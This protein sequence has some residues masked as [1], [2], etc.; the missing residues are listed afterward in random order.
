M[1][2]Y[3]LQHPQEDI[4]SKIHHALKQIER[5]TNKLFPIE[6]VLTDLGLFNRPFGNFGSVFLTANADRR[7][8]SF[9]LAE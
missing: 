3:M 8:V 4:C 6:S 2:L 7:A 5:Y 9:T 1:L